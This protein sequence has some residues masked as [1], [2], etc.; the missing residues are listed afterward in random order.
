MTLCQSCQQPL[1]EPR[2]AF[3]PH[4]GTALPPV[5]EAADPA[6]T[7]ER[8]AEVPPAPLPLP[9]TSGAPW[10]RRAEVGFFTALV[11][12][13]L[14]VLS[15]PR[16]FFRRMSASGGMGGPLAYAVL[17]GY[18]GLVATAVYDA[19]FEALLGS[20]SL[21]GSGAQDF[22]LGPEFDRA[23]ALVEGGPG[24][25]IQ[26]LLGP[27]LLAAGVFIAAG[28]NHLALMLLGGARR[29][30]EA[31]FRVVAYSKAASI[32]SLVPLCGPF[33]AI[34]WSAVASIVGLQVVHDTTLGKAVGAV[35]L[36]VVVACCCCAGTIGALAA[37][38][39]SAVP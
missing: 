12:T 37:L 20:E 35:L 14:Q 38:V 36:P 32:V 25:L 29:G 2:G 18:V 10:E 21:V 13:T 11:D 17:V 9:E 39:A 6:G 33:V 5:P 24:L 4:C 16:E 26:I 34:V 15:R 19:I 22:G 7:P 8:P 28:L 31:T 23:L 27:F 30:F 1:P 3:C